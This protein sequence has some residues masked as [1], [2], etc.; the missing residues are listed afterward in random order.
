M[1]QRRRHGDQNDEAGND[2]QEDDRPRAVRQAILDGAV[3]DIGADA[4]MFG[5]FQHRRQSM[6][7]MTETFRRG[8]LVLRSRCSLAGLTRADECATVAGFPQVFRLLGA[9]PGLSKHGPDF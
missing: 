2:G 9:R 8:T 1:A 4:Q 7:R 6:R 3:P 5:G